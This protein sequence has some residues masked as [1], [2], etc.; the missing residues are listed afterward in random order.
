MW[1][2]GP[3]SEVFYYTFNLV[4]SKFSTL[5]TK[6]LTLDGISYP[7][8]TIKLTTVESS[9]IDTA[10]LVDKNTIP[11][12]NP[13]PDAANNVLGLAMKTGNSGW[14][15][16]GETNYYSENSVASRDGDSVYIIENSGKSP[17]LDFYLYHSNNITVTQELGYYRVNA[18]MSWKK[19]LTRGTARIII[20]IAL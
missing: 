1:Y 7:N 9:L 6:S 17:A 13:D 18:E 10:N 2:C 3:D 14:A 4:A 5:G 12:I 19:N 20:D 8:A 11:N 16:N 15:M